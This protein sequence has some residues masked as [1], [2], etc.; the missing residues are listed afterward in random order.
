MMNYL[1]RIGKSLMA[2]IAVLPAAAL[3]VGIGQWFELILKTS[4]G[5]TTILYQSGIRIIGQMGMLFAVGLA[6]GMSKDKHG[7]AA[8]TGLVGWL[9]ITKLLSPECVAILKGID[10]EKVAYAFQGNRIENQFVGILV[11]LISA[12]VYNRTHTKE[13]PMAIAFFSGR[14]LSAIVNSVAMIVVSCFLFFLW[15]PI[16]SAFVS[17]GE[18]IVKLDAVGAGI[19]GLFNRLLIPLGLHHALNAVF[20]FDLAGINDIPKYLSGEGVLGKTGMYQAGFFPIMMFGLP[21][22]A[23][24][25]YHCVE[26]K[27]R[28]RVF[29]L[30][31]SAA[32]ASFFTGI[33][34]PLEFSFM[35][36][37]PIL[38]V[39]HAFYTGLSLFIAAQMHWISGFGFSAGLIDYVLSFQN[40]LAVQNTMLSIQG[41]FFF[42]L[43]YITFRALIQI[44][45]LKTIGRGDDDEREESLEE[46]HGTQEVYASKA[47]ALLILLG[48]ENIVEIDNCATRL[49]LIV[50][51]ELEIERSTIKNLGFIDMIRPSQTSLQIIVG[52]SVEFVA[53]E[54]KKE[55]M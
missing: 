50:K 44:F 25:M 11:G 19:Y 49:R 13:L 14:R 16:F 9:V 41:I 21:G 45:D 30:L 43:Y 6:F 31:F 17:F 3:L 36:A 4:N 38:Y 24:A 28:R 51:K 20:L 39:V 37:A 12:T 55:M 2:P 26:K 1:Q 53:E 10:V 46:H 35:F 8:L 7:M 42:G 52:P 27:R 22:G 29:G 34:E 32:V 48:K 23:L 5:V 40:P 18:Y 15:P 54:M 47:K 33:T